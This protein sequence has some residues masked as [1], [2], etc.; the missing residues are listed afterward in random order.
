MMKLTI[1]DEVEMKNVYEDYLSFLD[2][3]LAL[4]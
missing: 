4:S 2:E 3:V 1:M